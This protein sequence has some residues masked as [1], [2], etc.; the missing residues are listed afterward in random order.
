MD[1]DPV[2]VE[3]NVPMPSSIIIDQREELREY[4]RSLLIE[5]GWR[6]QVANL[7]R[8]VIQKYGVEHVKLSQIVGEVREEARQRVPE[9]VRTQL[10]SKIKEL[11]QHQ[12]RNLVTEEKHDDSWKLCQ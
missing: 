7:S 2:T 6:D 4:L 10:M 5:C 8:E 1:P 9:N 3:D 11:Q 12:E